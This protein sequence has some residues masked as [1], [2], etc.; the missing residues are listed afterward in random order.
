MLT[1]SYL[2]QNSPQ[3]VNIPQ[4]NELSD[5]VS[6]LNFPKWSAWSNPDVY[7]YGGILA[8]VASLESLL[9]IKAAE[10]LDKKHRRTSKDR[11][12]VAQGIGNLFAGL[13]GGIPVTSVVV[14]TSVN[15]QAGSKTKLSA[16]LHGFYLLFAMLLIPG[17]LNRIPLCSLAAV[18]IFTGYKLSSPQLIKTVYKQGPDRFIPFLATLVGIVTLNLLT[19]I[20]I[21]LLTSLF[22]ILKSN[23]QAR[24]DIIKEFY[25]NGVTQRL[26]LPQQTTFL[27]KASLIEELDDIPK[28]S[29]FIID[30]RYSKYIDK[31]IIELI[32]DFKMEQAP[33][34]NISLNLIG[35]KKEYQVHDY[36]N[37]INVTTYDIQA[38][39][40]PQR[41]L[42]VL[43]EGNQRFLDDTRIHRNLMVDIK[44]TSATQHPIAVVVGCI[45][46]RVPVETIFD[47][48]FG[49]LFCIR[50]A[51][52]VINEDILASIEYACHVVG[53]KLVVVLGHTRC[54]AI[55][56]ACSHPEKDKSHIPQLLEKLQPAIHA[57]KDKKP[58]KT[59]KSRAYLNYVTE[60]NV[61]NTLSQI[62]ENSTVL[63]PQFDKQTLGMVGAIYDVNTGKVQFKNF[64]EHATKLHK[65]PQEKLLEQLN[66]LVIPA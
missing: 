40:S 37:F 59:T 8:I 3:L 41:A 13:I 48:S 66:A 54:G 16:I 12:L 25:P 29:Q 11:E 15:I 65:H 38:A 63:K 51:G 49:D 10:K 2:A 27:N 58:A 60:L 47:M 22:F 35:F 20:I 61:A 18:L 17:L 34:K 33:R 23:S 44:H 6:Q 62:Y 45:D 7:L 55:S 64:A 31:E 30:A 26:I 5:W 32:E 42:N 21:G 19:G 36:I 14:R 24:L 56:A 28:K 4:H 46:S 43:H 57:A 53:A 1:H 39:L 50:I 9:N 52:N